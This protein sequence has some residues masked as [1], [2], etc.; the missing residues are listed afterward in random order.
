LLRR[1]RVV[2]YGRPF[3]AGWGLT[4]DIAPVDRGRSLSLEELVAGALILY[5]RYLDPVTRL[6]CSPEIL[7]ERLDQ[8]DIWR[9]G[10]LVISRQMQG[11]LAKSWKRMTS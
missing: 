5:P 4:A 1:R 11:V 9:R 10:P 3:Y 6:P 2:A 8:P 7:I